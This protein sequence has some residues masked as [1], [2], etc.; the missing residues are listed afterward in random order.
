[1]LAGLVASLVGLIGVATA[2]DPQKVTGANYPLAMKFSKEFV[3]QHVPEG[4]SSLVSPKW[5]GKTDVFW[6]SIRTPDGVRYWKVDCEKKT[7]VPL[8]D[9]GKLAAKLSEQSQ[10]P[11]DATTLKLASESVTDDGGKFRFTSGEYRY[12]YDIS[13]QKLAK[14][15]RAPQ[16]PQLSPEMLAQMTDEQRERLRELQQRR[17]DEQQEDQQQE[18]REDQQQDQQQES[19]QP[20]AQRRPPTPNYKAYSPDKKKYVYAYKHNLYLAAEGK[21]NEATQLTKDG[22]EEYSFAGGGF[23]F[24]G[25][26][27]SEGDPQPPATDRKTQ[28]RVTWSEDS[29]HFHV[30]RIDGRGV[31]EL[32]LVN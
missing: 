6:Y 17:R 29:K 28:P 32:F 1:M 10:K 27:R 3:A 7:R 20:P 23:G 30:T 13:S 5:I 31:K 24:G 9:T 14:L 18:R 19:D 15:G 16:G 12:E 2:A 22:A 11:T 25:T 8:F 26:R 4:G 21:E